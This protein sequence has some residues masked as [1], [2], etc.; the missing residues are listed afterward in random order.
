[1]AHKDS[2]TGCM[3]A[4]VFEVF[5]PEELG[6]IF[7]DMGEDDRKQEEDFK[8][9]LSVPYNFLLNYHKYCDEDF[10]PLKVHKVLDINVS[11]AI[12]SY[13]MEGKIDVS[14]FH[15]GAFKRGVVAF[16]HVYYSST[17]MEPEDWNTEVWFLACGGKE[18]QI[19]GKE[20]CKC[21]KFIDRGE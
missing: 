9:D 1:M 19:E 14:V 12:M 5:K 15:D 17:M 11:S 4:D 8:N 18:C 6:E 10:Y 2:F 3:V 16:S 13:K 21:G 7:K 20:K